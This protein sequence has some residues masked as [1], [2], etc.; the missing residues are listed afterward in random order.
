[1]K[2]KLHQF[3]S[4]TQITNLSVA[5]GNAK[6]HGAKVKASA[7]LKILATLA[8]HRTSEAFLDEVDKVRKNAFTI[9][10][11]EVLFLDGKLASVH[12]TIKVKGCWTESIRIHDAILGEDGYLTKCEVRANLGGGEAASDANAISV[13]ERMR[14]HQI[15]LNYAFEICEWI[16][17]NKKKLKRSD[18]DG[19]K[20]F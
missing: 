10:D 14:N 16:N 11:K 4:R 5:I 19:W 2:I 13:Q 20:V 12:L 6:V 8:G 1:M 15:A 9:T 18:F 3:L 7:F 17:S